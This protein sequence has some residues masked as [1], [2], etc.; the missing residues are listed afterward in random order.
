MPHPNRPNVFR[1]IDSQAQVLAAG[2]FVC[3]APV[4]KAD[5]VT[6]LGLYDTAE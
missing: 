2:W 3:D 4:V 5:Y 6:Q 1:S